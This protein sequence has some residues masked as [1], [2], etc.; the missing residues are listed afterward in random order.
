MFDQQHSGAAKWRSRDVSEKDLLRQWCIRDTELEP[1][2]YRRL[3]GRA[4]RYQTIHTY[5]MERCVCVCGGFDK[6]SCVSS[7][8]LSRSLDTAETGWVTI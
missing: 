2:T 5:W 4:T 6:A 3:P 1:S 8:K 7:C